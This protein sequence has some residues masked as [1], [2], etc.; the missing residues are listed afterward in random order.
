MARRS[1]QSELANDL[2]QLFL[3][4]PAWWC[5]SVVAFAYIA[6]V[7]VLALAA[8]TNPN[9][10]GLAQSGPLFGCMAAGVVL[11]AGLTAAIK[12]VERRTLHDSEEERVHTTSV[13][14]RSIETGETRV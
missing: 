12:K 1:K 11:A 6:V 4:F 13:V 10:Q 14:S 3:H 9:F 2:H 7:V 5:L 8:S